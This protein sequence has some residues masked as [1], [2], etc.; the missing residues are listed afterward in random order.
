MGVKCLGRNEGREA[1]S[2]FGALPKER[3]SESR[4][5][6]WP[7]R[8][9]RWLRKSYPFLSLNKTLIAWRKASRIPL[10]ADQQEKTALN[11]AL[12]GRAAHPG[13]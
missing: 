11:P 4:V 1:L 9:R 6:K 7:S 5:G 3:R 12:G 13:I 10:F 8:T 2:I